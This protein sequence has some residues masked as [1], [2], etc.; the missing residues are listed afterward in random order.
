MDQECSGGYQYIFVDFEYRPK[1]GI[2]GNPLEVI[3]MVSR[4]LKTGEYKRLWADD[5]YA[6]DDHPF[7]TNPK[8]VLV[9]YYASAETAVSALA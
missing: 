1:D 8:V 7:G 9:A 5:L 4:N 6:L 2:E 3:C